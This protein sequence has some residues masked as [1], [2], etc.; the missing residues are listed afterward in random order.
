MNKQ[1]SGLFNRTS[2]TKVWNTSE[3]WTHVYPTQSNYEGTD[4]PRSF[5]VDTPQGQMWTHNNATEHMYEAIISIKDTPSLKNSEPKLYT[6]FILYDYWKS[7]GVAVR[8]GIL[9]N[10]LI[11]IGSWEFM[12]SKPRNSSSNPVIKH[13]KFTGLK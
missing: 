5:S 10:K 9:Y 4:L 2:G 11:H 12:F 7:L 3:V 1:F 13:A 8:D 6:Q